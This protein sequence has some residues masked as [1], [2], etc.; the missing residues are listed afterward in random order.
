[1]A[2]VTKKA[3]EGLSIQRPMAWVL[4]LPP[5]GARQQRALECE[6]AGLTNDRAFSTCNTAS[7][8]HDLNFKWAL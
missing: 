1:M 5:P 8:A 3:L 7:S 6:Q 4:C 2:Q